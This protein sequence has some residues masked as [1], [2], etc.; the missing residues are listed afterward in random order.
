M[1]GDRLY[2][3][4]IITGASSGLGEEFARQLASRCV[5]MT[6]VA[7]RISRLEEIAESLRMDFPDLE[8]L[9]MEIDLVQPEQREWFLAKIREGEVAPDLLINNAG[10]GDY[11]AFQSSDWEKLN[12][13][14]QLNMVALTHIVQGVLPQMVSNGGG[15][16]LNVSSMASVLPIPDFAVYAA[17]KAY[18]TSF[19]E[20][21]RLELME[22]HINVMA[23]CPGPV[24]TEF[25]SVAM[26]GEERNVLPGR[27]AFYVSK[28]NVV[29]EALRGL[30]C[31]QARV[32]PG[33]K[34]ALLAAAISAIPMLILR[35]ILQSRVGNR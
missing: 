29:L 8:V 25:G 16:I 35:P 12:H 2:Q 18:V 31:G 4:V 11:G 1:S 7:R 13:M 5:R 9:C 20:A 30:E 3:S 21:L 28:E 34:V 26:R 24:H 23:L 32:F 22:D 10:M 6:L 15:H 19:S 14:M 17:T 27:E 33:W